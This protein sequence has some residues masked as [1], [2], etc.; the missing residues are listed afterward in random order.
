MAFKIGS[1]LYTNQGGSSTVITDTGE[2]KGNQSGKKGTI[3]ADSNPGDSTNYRVSLD[4]SSGN[5]FDFNPDYSAISAKTYLIFDFGG[6][7]GDYFSSN[8]RNVPKHFE[9][10]LFWHN[11][12]DTWSSSRN[13]NYF[14]VS[15]RWVQIIKFKDGVDNL[16]NS[17]SGLLDGSTQVFKFTSVESYNATDECKPYYGSLYM[18]NCR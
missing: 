8:N 17:N 12:K 14:F 3:I 6:S 9:F 15:P 4:L 7:D 16:N 13:F 2:A 18:R 1:S 5:Y 11:Y 10:Y